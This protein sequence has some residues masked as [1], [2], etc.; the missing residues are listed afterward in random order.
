MEET[1]PQVIETAV[2][3]SGKVLRV[4]NDRIAKPGGTP[5]ERDVVEHPDSVC[6]VAR[7]ADG[8]VILVRQYRH[9][10]GAYLWELPAGKIDPGETPA[11]AFARELVEECGVQ[12][13][14]LRLAVTFFTSPGILT[15]R[16]HVFVAEGCTTGADGVNEGEIARWISVSL[17]EAE[18]MISRGEIVDAKTIVGITWAARG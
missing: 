12:C 17:D 14:T 13:G 6:G 2:R 18:S 4:R 10:A 3:Y 1:T 9:P 8:S 5:R 16:M 11:E 7:L 15:E